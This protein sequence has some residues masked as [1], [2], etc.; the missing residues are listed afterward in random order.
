MSSFI[1]LRLH[2]TIYILEE[3]TT[4]DCSYFNQKFTT[5]HKNKITLKAK[6]ATASHV[7]FRQTLHSYFGEGCPYLPLD[8]SSFHNYLP[9]TVCFYSIYL[10]TQVDVIAVLAIPVV[11]LFATAGFPE[12]LTL[13]VLEH[14]P[15]R[16][17]T[18]WISSGPP[19]PRFVGISPCRLSARRSI[20]TDL[21]QP[22][23]QY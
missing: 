9:R 13:T 15:C 4:F 16:C 6:L 20:H 10:K 14:R 12:L 21:R 18:W 8:C 5:W 19:G 1:T 22:S 11:N 7:L 17:G 3:P 2:P 23:R